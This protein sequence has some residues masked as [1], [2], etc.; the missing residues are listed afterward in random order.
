[1]A[2][3]GP[4]L[5]PE[6]I[7]LAEALVAL[8][9]LA[10]VLFALGCI[11]CVHGFVLAL[12]SGTEKAVG[13]IPWA[14]KVITLPLHKIEQKVTH[15]LGEAERSL[16]AHVAHSWHQLAALVRMV[17]RELEG[18]AVDLFHLNAWVMH[19][20]TPREI[21]RGVKT[22][23]H[24]I[25]TAQAIE[26][27]ALWRLDRAAEKLRRMVVQGVLPRLG[28]IEHEL[29][30]VVEHDIAGLRARTRTLE[31]EALREF[32][33][34]RSRPWLVVS[35]AFVGAV[36]IALRRLGLGWLRCRN[37]RR[38]GKFLCGLPT[39]LIDDLLGFALAFL[40]VVDPVAIAKVAIETE[41]TMH[42]LITKIAELHD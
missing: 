29:D 37:V 18:L 3:L 33:W 34:L 24:P 35:A 27:A 16:D 15:F 20:L 17:G 6:G 12:F 4:E 10:I 36:A 38:T 39:G 42:G 30:H 2:E 19:L 14:G 25:R 7:G 26:R 28:R 22:L 11:Y 1:M 31:Q 32:K 40:V 21:W 9:D 41:E 23:L 8:A 13:W 5:A